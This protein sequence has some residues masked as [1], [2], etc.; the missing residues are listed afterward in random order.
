[1]IL[2]IDGDAF[3]ASCEVVK[4]PKL[5]GKPVVTGRERGIASAMTYEA[6]AL[7]VKRGMP[8]HE[9]RRVCPNA[10][11]LPSDYESYSLYSKRMFE[12]VRR[13]T[14]CVEEYSIDECFADLEN[15][16]RLPNFGFEKISRDIKETLQ[17]ELGM[18]FSLGLAP[19]K[20]LAKVASKWQKPNGFT[21]ITSDKIN[22]FLKDWPVEK[23]W[24]I[25]P[26]T[27]I[28]LKKFNIHSSFQFASQLR[29]W[30]QKYMDKPFCEIW[31]ELNGRS[32]YKVDPKPKKNYQS[33]SKT[34]TFTP[35][36]KE[37]AIILSELS[38][39]VENACI[40]ARRY[41]LISNK[42]FFFIKTQDFSYRGREVDL[43]NFTNLP[44][45]IMPSIRRHLDYVFRSDLYR[46]TGVVLMNLKDTS[47]K[48][49]DLFG[50]F[51]KTESIQEV[52]KEID[53]LDEKFGKHTVFLGSSAIALKKGQHTGDR[54]IGA[55]RTNNL[56]KGENR[57]QRL[58]IP[59]LGT[60]E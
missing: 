40:K 33:I 42:I 23:I 19:T 20:V 43:E 6:K 22:F 24:G 60:A 13:Y 2:H 37:K 31:Y 21:V 41:N 1:M 54:A 48:E 9:I 14:S 56:F 7:G 49:R 12:I 36:T 34:R 25:G 52:Y 50:D 44:Q 8:L 32:V 15:A 39:N 30:V 58:A 28:Y 46:A 17:K 3:F 26:Q 18:T 38:K 51:K 11:I 35:P 29:I 47:M 10:I 4:N 57:R 45:E 59:F 55:E 5:K 16:Y 53:K 27:T